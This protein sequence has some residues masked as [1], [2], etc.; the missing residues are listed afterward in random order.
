MDNRA[1][2]EAGQA[3]RLDGPMLEEMRRERRLLQRFNQTDAGD[4]ESL[5]R[6]LPG[7]VAAAGEG[8][9]ICPPFYC[10]YGTG[11]RM[12]DRVF[13][14]FNL[15]ILDAAPVTF[16]NDVFIGPNVSIYTAGH[17]MHP[18]G[19]NA[20][21]EYAL[22][23]TVGDNVWICGN[24]VILPGVTIGEGCVIGAG[25]VVTRSIP[26]HSFAAGNPCRVIRAIPEEERRCLRRDTPFDREAWDELS[27]LRG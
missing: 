7:L 3:Y 16:G 6:Q 10:D 4:F 8:C 18:L 1:R 13:A 2:R 27:A 20:G 23:V 11:V 12:G 14:N 24:C 9:S 26:P 5:R 21:F 17:P 15:T 19:R 22:P 25:S